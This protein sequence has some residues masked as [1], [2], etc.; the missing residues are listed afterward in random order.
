MF[1]L[2]I[3][4]EELDLKISLANR[5]LREQGS[6]EI[7]RFFIKILGQSA[8]IEAKIDLQLFA[9]IDVDAYVNFNSYAKT[10]FSSVLK[11]HNLFYDELSNEIWMPKET[12]YVHIFKGQTFDGFIA[13]A[14]FVLVSKLLK[15]PA[16]NRNILIE[17]LSKEPS[18]LFFETVQRI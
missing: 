18:D 11:K 1:M 9:T 14:E 15:A 7:P 12:Q 6:L 13:Q 5:E 4:F 8:L 10:L 3:I 16:K 2:K 17:Y